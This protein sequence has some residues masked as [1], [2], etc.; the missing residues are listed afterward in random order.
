MDLNT[1]LLIQPFQHHNFVLVY[2]TG[3]LTFKKAEIN[4]PPIIFQD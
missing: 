1:I 3:W 2:K 4:Y